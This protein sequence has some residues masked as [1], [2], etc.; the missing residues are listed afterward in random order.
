MTSPSVV[1]AGAYRVAVAATSNLVSLSGLLT[2][3]GYTLVDG[4]TVLV[5]GQTSTLENGVWVASATAWSRASSFISGQT[6]FVLNGTA[7]AGKLWYLKTPPGFEIGVSAITITDLTAAGS[8]G[9]PTDAEYLVGALNGS[10]TQE[11]LVTNTTTISWD[12]TTPGQ[13]KANL[14]QSVDIDNNARVAVAKNSGA[15]VGTRRKLNLVEGT[16]VTLTVSDDVANEKVDVTIAASGGGGGTTGTA[17]LDFGADWAGEATVAVLSTGVGVGSI[18]QAWVDGLAAATADH[19]VDE[20]LLTP[21][22]IVC[23]DKNVG[24]GFTI[25]AAASLAVEGAYGKYN[26]AWRY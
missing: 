9:A 17:V 5:T 19:S 25:H 4:D 6:F 18:P 10:L 13:A 11:R 14:I 3:D 16:N 2:I 12:V 23:R 24:V 7:G 15:T 1:V 8:G 22:T 26:L 20:H 21:L